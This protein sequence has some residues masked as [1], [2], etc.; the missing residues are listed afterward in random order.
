MDKLQKLY[1]E[2]EQL[3]WNKDADNF[4]V[5]NEA[6]ILVSDFSGVIFDFALVYD[7]PVIYTDTEFDV[8]AYDAWWIKNPIWTFEVLPK[9]GLKL[10]DENLGSLKQVIDTCLN[11][12][13]YAE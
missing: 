1:P 2:T 8:S 11:D 6:D 9:L 4:F 7:K 10:S 5:L 13:R 12:S 3:R